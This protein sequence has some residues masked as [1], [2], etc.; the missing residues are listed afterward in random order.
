MKT[1][2]YISP[3]V[4]RYG[5][6][7]SMIANI[8]NIMKHGVNVLL[9]IPTHGCI[10]ELLEKYSINYVIE[11]FYDVINHEDRVRIHYGIGKAIV[12]TYKAFKIR[13]YITKNKLNPVVVHS[14]SI[15][16]DFGVILS[17][18]L[19]VP[20]IQHI[21]EL[22]EYDFGMTFDLG[23]NHFSKF[24][25]KSKKII[26]ISDAVYDYYKNYL[27]ENKMI[28][29]YNGVSIDANELLSN[30][31]ANEIGVTNIVLVGRLSEEKGQLQAIQATEMIKDK[32]LVHLDLWGDGID[33]AMLE[34]YVRQH[35]LESY[36]KFCGYS[37]DIPYSKY[38][39]ALVCSKYEA[40]GRV[41]VEYM[42]HGLPVIGV[43][44]GG[45]R[46]I[47]QNNITGLLYEN[48]AIEELEKAI[49]K[50]AQDAA[51]R[52]RL[53]IAGFKR[54]NEE[55]SE[56]VYCGKVYRIYEEICPMLEENNID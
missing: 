3:H 52:N 2:V 37:P 51:F 4:D 32:I 5:A 23:I 33:R 56:K 24:V 31:D 26:C 41:T 17:L 53:S 18:I 27:P 39:I 43:N 21:R 44:T 10:E 47:I 11:K 36:V 9:I 49:L 35:K 34:T 42:F 48:G 12:N 6:E 7:R 13:K 19:K 25:G 54:A 1:I 22:G 14:N 45:T 15:T 38:Q 55:F 16:S 20:H 29:I 46:E 30:R 40:F 28:K 8:R 50:V